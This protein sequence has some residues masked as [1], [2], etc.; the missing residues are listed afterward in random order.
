MDI[1]TPKILI[2]AKKNLLKSRHNFP[3]KREISKPQISRFDFP[4]GNTKYE[5]LAFCDNVLCTI[6]M[7]VVKSQFEVDVL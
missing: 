7:S 1:S 5:H 6:G 2:F 3:V 4:E